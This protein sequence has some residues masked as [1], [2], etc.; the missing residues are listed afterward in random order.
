MIRKSLLLTIILIFTLSNLSLAL[1]GG[2]APLSSLKVV[3]VQSSKYPQGEEIDPQQFSTQL[4]H[5]GEELYIYTIDKGYGV[6]PYAEMNGRKLNLIASKPLDFNNDNIIDGFLK[7][8]D[9]SG[10]QSGSFRYRNISSNSSSQELSVK[11][12]IQ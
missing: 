10:F 8:W 2:A 11:V 3:A 6:A 12:Y 5:G 7:R 1:D 9:A 4:D